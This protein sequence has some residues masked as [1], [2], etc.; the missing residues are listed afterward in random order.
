MISSSP[1]FATAPTVEW[2]PGTTRVG[3]ACTD[4]TGSVDNQPDVLY[5]EVDVLSRGVAPP[6]RLGAF[7]GA[8]MLPALSVL[9]SGGLVWQDKTSGDWQIFASVDP[10]AWNAS[11]RL[12]C[13]NGKA[14]LVNTSAY[15][16][17]WAAW[18]PDPL[19]W[20]TA[21]ANQILRMAPAGPTVSTTSLYLGLENTA[22]TEVLEPVLGAPHPRMVNTTFFNPPTLML[23]WNLAEV[24]KSL[25]AFSFYAPPRSCPGQAPLSILAPNGGEVL[26]LG[27]GASVRWLAGSEVGPVRI[28][29]SSD[30]GLTWQLV[31][32]PAPNNGLSGWTPSTP[33][34]KGRI[35]ITATANPAVRA[36]S[37]GP[38][39]VR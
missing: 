9:G 17:F 38:F 33:T 21:P 36:V 3:V 35:R 11:A 7:P 29:F 34:T 31:R 15:R 24:P 14:P 1:Q 22:G 10:G 4:A 12:V 27:Q 30:D 6:V 39:I 23:R 37:A 5:T 20:K 2:L 26:P 32:N 13:L 18:P 16:F 8:A 19:V 28:E 25:Y